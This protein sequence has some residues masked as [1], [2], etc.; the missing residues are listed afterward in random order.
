MLTLAVW[1]TYG[2]FAVAFMLALDWLMA[3]K[4]WKGT[5]PG[6]KSDRD[7]EGGEE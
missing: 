1:T 2:F 5:I 4:G 6:P 7:R 3:R